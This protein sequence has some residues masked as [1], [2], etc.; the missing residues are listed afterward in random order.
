MCVGE[1]TDFVQDW[2]KGFCCGFSGPL[3]ETPARIRVISNILLA[4]KADES[5][6]KCV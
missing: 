6:E 2:V 3:N 5:D 4:M 1:P